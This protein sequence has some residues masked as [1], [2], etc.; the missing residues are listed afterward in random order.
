MEHHIIPIEARPRARQVVTADVLALRIVMVNV[1]FV[2]AHETA[3]VLV[4]TGLPG[5]ARRIMQVAGDLFGADSRPRAIVLTHGH[6]DHVGGLEELL[7]HWDVPVFAHPFELP[8]LTG[9]SDYPP[10]D[11]AAGGGAMAFFSRLY[12][13]RGI[14]LGDHVHE[15]PDDFSIPGMPGWRWIHTP[16]HTPGHV[17]YFRDADR[18]L[19][20]GDAF[21]TTKQESLLSVLTQHKE[22]H[23]PPKYF[24][25]DWQAARRSVEALAAL[26]PAV[27]ATGHGL[28]MRGERLRNGLQK[29][30]AEFN[31]IARPRFGRYVKKP[32]VADERGV[33]S[34][35]PPV[36]DPRVSI[37]AG[38]GAVAAAGATYYFASRRS[39]A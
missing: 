4:D 13:R 12:P 23:G 19:I 16:G 31:Q 9:I 22:L 34:V 28:P 29:L 30:A 39:M 26:E 38:L 17:S 36:A 8:Y 7:S 21:V 27:A 3:W 33:V 18:T 11:P 20:A 5:S 32:A 2:G 25:P 35:P 14:D 24:T 1:F 15:L 6:F 37:L 10:A